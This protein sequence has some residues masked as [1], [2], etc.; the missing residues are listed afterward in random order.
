MEIFALA[1]SLLLG[2][3]LVP[4]AVFVTALVAFRVTDP[5]V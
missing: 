1:I 5:V 2:G 4:F 3:V